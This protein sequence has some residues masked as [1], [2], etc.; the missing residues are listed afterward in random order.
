MWRY[1]DSSYIVLKFYLKG[2][3][4]NNN[5]GRATCEEK[6]KATIKYRESL[7]K[8]RSE[9]KESMQTQSSVKKLKEE[10]Q[11]ELV[12]KFI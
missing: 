4:T 3:I 1:F 12:T 9:L 11:L 5:E 2:Q 6:E 8:K 7:I 10:D